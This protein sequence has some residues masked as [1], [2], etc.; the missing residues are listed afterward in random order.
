MSYQGVEVPQTEELSLLDFVDLQVALSQVRDEGIGQLVSV[1]VSD[2]PAN[3][4]EILAAR[5]CSLKENCSVHLGGI[6]SLELF[7][8][9]IKWSFRLKS[10]LP[11]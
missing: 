10:K 9:F 5:R 1:S 11:S 3:F 4:D 2:A 8:F 6:K 7:Q